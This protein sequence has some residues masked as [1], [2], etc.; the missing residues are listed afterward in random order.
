MFQRCLPRYKNELMTTHVKT[1]KLLQICKQVVTNL[2]TSCQQVVFALLVPSCCNKFGT[3][4]L[5]TTYV[6]SLM[7]LS[8]L[9]YKVLITSLIQPWYKK[10]VTRLTISDCNNIV[11][12]CTSELFKDYQNCTSPKD[13]CNLKSLRNS[14][15]AIWNLWEECM[16]FQIARE[17]ILLLINNIPGVPK[18][19]LRCLIS[20]NVKTIKAITLK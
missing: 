9:V 3:F 4:K 16:F 11:I 17:T 14:L 2:F 19:N 7:A 12:T 15:S 1:H 5:L 18:K 10:N 6:T 20:C 8:D 13:E